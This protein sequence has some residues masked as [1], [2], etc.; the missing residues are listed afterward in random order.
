MV[1]V[2]GA[3]MIS[4]RDQWQWQFNDNSMA[5]Q[6]QFNGN[7]MTT[8]WQFNGNSRYIPHDNIHEIKTHENVPF[9]HNV[10]RLYLAALW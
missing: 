2:N 8:Q 3:A 1:I 6:W 5:I 10:V 9:K 4:G 7:S